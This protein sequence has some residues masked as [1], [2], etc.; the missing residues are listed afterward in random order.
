[1]HVREFIVNISLL[2]LVCLSRGKTSFDAT[3]VG[4]VKPDDIKNEDDEFDLYRKRM[5][6]AYK[7]RPNPL[8]SK[9]ITCCPFTLKFTLPS[10]RNISFSEQSSTTLLLNLLHMFRYASEDNPTFLR[11]YRTFYM[12]YK[13]LLCFLI[14]IECDLQ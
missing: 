5:Q 13:M 4:A 12:L 8:V 9:T 7:F 6:L 11:L 14:S 1:M 2:V 10:F 3:G